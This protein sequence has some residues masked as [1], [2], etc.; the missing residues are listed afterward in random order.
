MLYLNCV[1]NSST[2]LF[3]LC[4]VWI[5]CVALE[6]TIDFGILICTF[7]TALVIFAFSSIRAVKPIVKQMVHVQ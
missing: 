6:L 3:Y 5:L 2:H 1:Q 4:Y 7:A